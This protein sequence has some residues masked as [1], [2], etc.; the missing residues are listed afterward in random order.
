M[1]AA[2]LQSHQAG[3]LN[4]AAEF[5]RQVLVVDVRRFRPLLGG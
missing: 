3:R 1:F 4:E 5:Y 2:A